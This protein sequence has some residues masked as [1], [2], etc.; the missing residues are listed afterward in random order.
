MLRRYLAY[1]PEEVPG[2]YRLLDSVA[3][4]CPGHGP[5][6]LL[7]ESAAE[8]GFQWDPEV[9]GWE[10]PGLPALSTLAGPIQHFR[11]VILEAWRNVV[12][13]ALCARKGFR[14]GALL[15]FSG[16]LQLL[17]SCH[18][19]PVLSN[20]AG[21]IQHFPSAVLEGWGGKVSADLC[22][23]KGFRGGPWL[24]I[25]GTLQLLN[26]DHVR[27]RDEALL[28]SFLVGGV[29]NGF[30]LSKVKGQQVSCWFCGGDDNDGHLFW[31]CNF[32]PC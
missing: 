20:W 15:D 19:L 1:R 3:E 6:H 17:E 21:P 28:R 7:V 9:L 27:E 30:L 23:R 5:A 31:D 16:T 24:D 8:V 25:D 10:R 2:V 22:A 4:G 26:S 11:A 13:A 14:E 29:W 32:P 12:S 18:A